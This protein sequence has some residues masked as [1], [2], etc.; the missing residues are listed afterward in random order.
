[1]RM[2]AYHQAV[3]RTMTT[4]HKEGRQKKNSQKVNRISSLDE[5]EITI[6]IPVLV[7]LRRDSSPN[8]CKVLRLRSLG[9][10]GALWGGGQDRIPKRRHRTRKRRSLRGSHGA[11][12]G[13][14]QR[15]LG[16]L[17]GLGRLRGILLRRS[18]ILVMRILLLLRISR[19]LRHCQL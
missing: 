2:A 7:L 1:M 13:G 12:C 10:G 4:A 17:G 9:N 14:F 8:N 18:L 19:T 11:L 15:G 6:A 16:G 5:R 3:S